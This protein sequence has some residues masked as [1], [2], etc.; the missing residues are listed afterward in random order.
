MNNYVDT[1]MVDSIDCKYIIYGKEVGE[2]GTP[3]L[4]GFIV[5]SL[6]KTLSAAIKSLPGCHVEIAKDVEAS[7]KYCSK[8]G[9]TTER[10]VR[11]MSQKRKGEV[12]VERYEAARSAA[13][14]GRWDDVPADIYIRHYGNLKKIRAEKQSVTTV[15]DGDLENLW[16]Y[17]P[18]GCGKS[19][20]VR[21][22]YPS[23]YVKDLNKWWDG[24]VD[25]DVVVVEDMDPFHKSLSRE[26]KIWSDRYSFPAEIKGGSLMIR[27]KKIIVTS[28]Y[29]I[30]EIWEDEQTRQALNRRFNSV[31]KGE[32]LPEA[33]GGAYAPIFTPLKKTL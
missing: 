9:L 8:D 6:Q 32:A 28:Q 7:I 13:E 27:P 19:R 26:F 5:F 12:E 4:Q 22:E 18:A 2:S 20:A 31:N 15:L 10:G 1:Q 24:Y 17:G 30:Q 3:H 33:A 29:S 16:I 14:Q 21:E 11:P 23:A 25:Q